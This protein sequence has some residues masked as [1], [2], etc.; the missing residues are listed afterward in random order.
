MAIRVIKNLSIILIIIGTCINL[1]KCAPKCDRVPE[2]T[3]A[4][5]S[6]PDG[7]FR[8]RITNDPQYYIPGESY[9]S[10]STSHLK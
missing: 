6:P 7:R 10:N 1:I 4:S 9:N 2:G 3:V 8:L 5:K